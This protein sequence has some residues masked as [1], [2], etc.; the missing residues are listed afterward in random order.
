MIEGKSSKIPRLFVYEK[1]I[2]YL[3]TTK[4]AE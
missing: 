3:V 1:I 4:N 2:V